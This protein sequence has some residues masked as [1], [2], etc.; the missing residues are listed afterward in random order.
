MYAALQT[1]LETEVWTEEN[2]YGKGFLLVWKSKVSFS[3][4]IVMI[5]LTTPPAYSPVSPQTSSLVKEFKRNHENA[6]KKKTKDIT[7]GHVKS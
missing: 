5:I 7:E 3:H 6:V 2:L 1:V 4:K